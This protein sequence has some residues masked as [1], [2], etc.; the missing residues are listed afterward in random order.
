MHRKGSTMSHDNP[1]LVP[2]APQASRQAI[3]FGIAA[4]GVAA[5]PAVALPALGAVTVPASETAPSGLV[6]AVAAIP[7]VDPVHSAIEIYKRQLAEFNRLDGVLDKLAR[8]EEEAAAE[9]LAKLRPTTPAGAGA[10]V[11]YVCSDIGEDIDVD[12]HLVALTTAADALATIDGRAR[13]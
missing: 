9:R 10:L 1:T 2:H 11:A 5:G 13:S 6:P 8:S 3:L 4:A 7:E 12:W